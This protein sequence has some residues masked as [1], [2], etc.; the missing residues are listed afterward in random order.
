MVDVVVEP[1]HWS[2]GHIKCRL[3][4]K[5]EMRCERRTMSDRGRS[6]ILLELYVLTTS[7]GGPRRT[8]TTTAVAGL[9]QCVGA[10]S[11]CS[12]RVSSADGESEDRCF[13]GTA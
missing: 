1:N 3:E 5:F 9:P 10:H 8:T 7:L 12:P 4:Y 6:D 13:P 11:V 2:T